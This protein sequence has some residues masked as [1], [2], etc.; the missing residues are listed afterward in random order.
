MLPA[1]PSQRHYTVED[2]FCIE[3]SADI[4]QEFYQGAIFA[5]AGGITEP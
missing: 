3:A 2:Y 1:Q 4:R 5:M